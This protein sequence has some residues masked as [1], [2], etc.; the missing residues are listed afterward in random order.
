MA[1]N[2]STTNSTLSTQ[3]ETTLT[4]SSNEFET[5][6]FMKD[7]INLR[8][9]QEAIQNLSGWCIRNRK[10][11]AYKIARCWLKCI[12]KV[13]LEQKLTLFHL[14][15][16]VVQHSKKRNYDDLLKKFQEQIREAMPHLKNT[17]ITEKIIRCLNIWAERQIFEGKFVQE[18]IAS[19][20]PSQNRAEQDILDNFQPQQLCT[21]IK[22][23][24]ALEDDTDYKLRAVK[25]SELSLM[26]K[27]DY[28][29]R[30][31]LKDREHGNDYINAAEDGQKHL[32]Q[33]I[34]A[35]D[36][37]LT[38][39]RQVIEMLNHAGKYY[40]SLHG[41]ASIVATAYSNFGRRIKNQHRKLEDKIKSI[42]DINDINLKGHL[43]GKN[44]FGD[45]QASEYLE[46]I[47]P[48]PSPDYDAPSPESYSQEFH[49]SNNTNS[50][51][52]NPD[53]TYSSAT[54]HHSASEWSTS[55]DLS[56]KSSVLAGNENSALCSQLETSQNSSGFS[57]SD[58]LTKLAKNGDSLLHPSHQHEATNQYANFSTTPVNTPRSHPP[59][60]SRQE[61]YQDSYKANTL[62][63]GIVSRE[64]NRGVRQEPLQLTTPHPATLWPKDRNLPPSNSC[65]ETSDN[66]LS[67]NI[68][69]RSFHW[70]QSTANDPV[71]EWQIPVQEDEHLPEGQVFRNG[72]LQTSVSKI[73][74][75]SAVNNLISLTQ[76]STSSNAAQKDTN[77][78]Y[79]F[80]NSSMNQ[81]VQSSLDPYHSTNLVHDDMEICN[82]YDETTKEPRY[83]NFYDASLKKQVANIDKMQ[84]PQNQTNIP[85]LLSEEEFNNLKYNNP[86][87]IEISPATITSSLSAIESRNRMLTKASTFSNPPP[88]F[89]VKQTGN[90]QFS[91]MPSTTLPIRINNPYLPAAPRE[92]T[93]K[94]VLEED[95]KTKSLQE[96]LRNL[97]GV[98]LDNRSHQD[99]LKMTMP[100][101]TEQSISPFKQQAQISP[102]SEF[103]R[104]RGYF[105]RG[106]LGGHFTGFQVAHRGSVFSGHQ[107]NIKP[108]I[109]ENWRGGPRT[110]FPMRN[111]RGFGRARHGPRW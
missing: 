90:T 53:Q 9:S 47:S 105:N 51:C 60:V 93:N 37:E 27:D 26:E 41:E 83:D 56:N 42:K 22:I 73:S 102:G 96:R 52:V 111:M 6:K 58:Y 103:R 1:F 15:N 24:K 84:I 30:Q 63:Q 74:C 19:I 72:E 107:S 80:K 55:K 40:N 21:Q 29:L 106:S 71:P 17:K 50:L 31:N 49:L 85:P 79:G 32:E 3:V 91:N 89:S 94:E 11:N 61:I 66:R 33:Y 88:G 7:L 64:T 59:L 20:D 28:S 35:I 81:V 46:D 34:K 10:N 108:L 65:F 5:E 104:G 109:G 70:Q 95:I 99:G 8:D 54:M 36:R 92:L 110:G 43:L 4:S 101:V 38:K 82:K 67:G 14:L 48:L 86:E 18:L 25:D 76:N 44:S 13:K 100:S 57:I 45:S 62:S 78:A 97:A 2:D 75:N 16:D 87:P 77:Q 12:K 69:Q 39:R 98:P 68:G 23:M